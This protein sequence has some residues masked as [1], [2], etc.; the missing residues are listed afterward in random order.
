MAL[1]MV[2]TFLVF[3]PA[4]D[5]GFVDWDDKV[6]LLENDRYRG[7]DFDRI[8][9]MFTTRLMQHFQP[10][11]WLTY[12]VDYAL[13]GM[14][15]WGYH[16]TSILLHAAAA[17]VFF[18][19]V[20]HLLYRAVGGASGEI[21]VGITAGAALAALTFG[22]HPL[23]AESVAWA[24][25]RRDVTSGLFFMMTLAAYLRAST[26]VGAA[27]FRWMGASL[28]AYL[29]SLMGKASGMTL[30]FVLIVLDAYPLGR[31]GS[32]G[33]RR[34]PSATRGVWLEKLPYL[35]L[36]TAVAVNAFLAQ[37]YSTAMDSIEAFPWSARLAIA[38]YA[39]AF[40]LYKTFLPFG[41]SP[42]Y[43][44]DHPF[45]PTAWHILLGAAVTVVV[46]LGVIWGARRWP[47]G[48]ALW[49]AYLLL[50]GPV[51]GLAKVGDQIAAD[52]YTYLPCLSWAVLVGAAWL[53][54]YC[55]RARS[56][57]WQR[58]FVGASAGALLVLVGLAQLTQRQ[59]GIWHDTVTLWRHAL[60]VDPNN[61]T[62]HLSLANWLT[63]EDRLR[64]SRRE[65]PTGARL[66]RDFATA[67]DHLRAAV[68]VR[69]DDPVF[70]VDLAKVLLVT[71]RSREAVEQLQSAVHLDADHVPAYLNLGAIHLAAG[72]VD[73]AIACFRTAI[74]IGPSD[75]AR[76]NLANALIRKKRYDEA[77]D[78]CRCVLGSDPDHAKAHNLWGFALIA[79]GDPNGG[80]PHLERALEIDASYATPRLQLAQIYV[81][82]NRR[83]QAIEL[84]REGT[85]LP[86]ADPR[87]AAAL[88]KLTAAP[89]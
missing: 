14:D 66:R 8:R 59:V 13:W 16:L 77:I 12:A 61:T 46:S 39:T 6:V 81:T 45:N 44:P 24:T 21:L 70:R 89:R 34:T 54:T 86:N 57:R 64:R 68:E 60:R 73:D 22:I 79:K 33:R 71:G 28:V 83:D 62:A 5:N 67:E 87:I 19:V 35:V 47:A 75:A 4:L 37:Y 51:S 18:W 53:S 84:L 49:A 23:R 41:L 9:W 29:L 74:D 3:W 65:D 82:R 88:A 20:R 58:A 36:G 80:I 7:F 48:L 42:M 72:R 50:L 40:Y 85:K 26:C 2:V 17:G 52:R 43:L 69:P 1:V 32:P 56:G 78:Q 27:R 10:L 76:L 31:L 30:P 38:S 25:E 63:D 15:P 11:T 55:R